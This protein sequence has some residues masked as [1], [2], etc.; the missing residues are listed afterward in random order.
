MRYMLPFR[1]SG[2]LRLLEAS[3]PN[4]RN[5]AVLIYWDEW[6]DDTVDSGVFIEMGRN[7]GG[8]TIDDD[9]RKRIQAAREKFIEQGKTFYSGSGVLHGNEP[10][11]ATT[12]AHEWLTND[13]QALHWAER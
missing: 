3:K 8:R 7:Q 10:R 4:G 1:M 12:L 2:E 13:L 5:E 6:A 11:P 9:T